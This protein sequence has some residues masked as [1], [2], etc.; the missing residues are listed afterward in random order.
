[1]RGAPFAEVGMVLLAALLLIWPLQR[2]TRAPSAARVDLVSSP[3][4]TQGLTDAWLEI[5]STA[6]PDSIQIFQGDQRLWEGGG[7]LYM[8]ADLRVDLSETRKPLRIEFRWPEDV[9]QAYTEFI[10]EPGAQPAQRQGF[11]S[12]EGESRIWVVDAEDLP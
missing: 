3:G 8:D 2:L 11:W 12:H 9:E 6:V 1:M 5:T 10:L 7:A 4:D